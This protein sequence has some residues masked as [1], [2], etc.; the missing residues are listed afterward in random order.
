MAG[1]DVA[2]GRRVRILYRHDLPLTRALTREKRPQYGTAS[3][4]TID[5]SD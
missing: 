5:G 2:F 1:D 4:R 3:G